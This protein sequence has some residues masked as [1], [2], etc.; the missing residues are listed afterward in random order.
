[1]VQ[2]NGKGQELIGTCQLKVCTDNSHLFGKKTEQR[3]STDVTTEV[4]Q[5]ATQTISVQ[6][7]GHVLPRE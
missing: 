6:V 2:E 7:Y 1:M 5:R 3:N 4:G